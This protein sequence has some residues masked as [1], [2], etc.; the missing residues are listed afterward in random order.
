MQLNFLSHPYSIITGLLQ[1]YI[2][3]SLASE[4]ALAILV[5]TLHIKALSSIFT[6]G[7]VP[8]S[9]QGITLLATGNGN[10]K[11][12]ILEVVICNRDNTCV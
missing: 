9:Q 8:F 7:R 4:V 5:E 6:H 2:I 1:L 10:F 3:L 12:L 11:E